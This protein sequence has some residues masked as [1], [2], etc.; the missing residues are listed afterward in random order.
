LGLT[1]VLV[2][3]GEDGMRIETHEVLPMAFL[4]EAWRLYSEAFDELRVVAVQRHVMLRQEFDEQMVDPRVR[5]YLVRSEQSEPA[6]TGPAA[7]RFAALATITNDLD[8]MHL[9]SPDYFRHRWPEHY[10]ERRIWYVGFN[11]IHPDFRGNGIFEQII[12]AMHRYIAQHPPSVVGL[13]FCRRNEER[14]QLPQ[15]IHS[16]LAQFDAVRSHRADTQAYWCY[17]LPAAS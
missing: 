8:A 7:G 1:H 13:D 2:W 17:E 16:V 5:K 10:A 3:T 9:I 14:Y 11:A 15:A 12:E 4:E 6:G